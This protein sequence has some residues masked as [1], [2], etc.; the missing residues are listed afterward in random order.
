MT[1]VN[2]KL[3]IQRAAL[4]LTVSCL[5]WSQRAIAAEDLVILVS[6][7]SRTIPVEDLE[8]FADRGQMSRQLEIYI[9]DYL[10]ATDAEEYRNGL[11]FEIEVDFVQYAKFLESDAGQCVLNVLARGIKPTPTDTS[12][13]Q[14]VKAGLVNGAAPDGRLTII[15]LV[16]S[17]PNKKLH[18]DTNEV[19]GSSGILEGAWEDLRASIEQ[20]GVPVEA[21]AWAGQT[22]L[23]LKE[24]DY[25]I[26][27]TAA[28]DLFCERLADPVS[29]STN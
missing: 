12:G 9:N 4:L 5:G 27:E 7:G 8:T 23:D 3:W 17:Y 10:D 21:D 20:A 1:I 25:D 24:V 16:R 29:N 6:G 15:D 28:Q 26:L 14:S 13:V 11:N 22:S 2:G 18:I 19:T